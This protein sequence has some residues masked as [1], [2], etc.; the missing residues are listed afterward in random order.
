[1]MKDPR[2]PSKNLASKFKDPSM[3][4][5][6]P[7]KIDECTGDAIQHMDR[8]QWTPG[9]SADTTSSGAS[10]VTIECAFVPWKAKAL[11]PIR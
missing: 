10:E 4:P 3:L 11:V 5:T 7:D 2:L 1:M 9:P 8:A 6:K